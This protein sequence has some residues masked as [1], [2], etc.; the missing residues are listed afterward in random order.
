MTEVF[1]GLGSNLGDRYGH[2]HAAINEINN[3]I[4]VVVR[5]SDL[6]ETEP[7]GYDS[8]NKYVNATVVVETTLSP[9]EVLRTTQQIE[10]ELG[11]TNKRATINDTTAYQDRTIDIDILIYEG[12]TMHTPQLTLPHPRIEERDFVKKP[13]SQI[14]SHKNKI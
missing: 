4:G 1:L 2:I 10:R 3:R 8:K 5:Q 6:I 12:I 13:L 7:Q 9:I 11:R 14:L